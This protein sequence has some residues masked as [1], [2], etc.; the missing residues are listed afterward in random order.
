MSQRFAYFFE[1]LNQRLH[2]NRELF[3][4]LG[5]GGGGG[6]GSLL[7]SAPRVKV[8]GGT[9]LY[10]VNTVDHSLLQVMYNLNVTLIEPRKTK[11]RKVISGTQ[12]HINGA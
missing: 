6:V 1:I 9:T 10:N 4:E 2:E 7:T 3:L 5:G 11:E 12:D 8:A